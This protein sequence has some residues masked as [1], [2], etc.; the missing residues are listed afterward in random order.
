MEPYHC[1]P[2]AICVESAECDFT[3]PLRHCIQMLATWDTPDHL[4][5]IIGRHLSTPQHVAVYVVEDSGQ[6]VIMPCG[7]ILQSCYMP[8]AAYLSAWLEGPASSFAC[9]K[10]IYNGF[11]FFNYDQSSSLRVYP[12]RAARDREFA[13]R[14]ISQLLPRALTYASREGGEM[15]FIIRP[16]F[17]GRVRVRGKAVIDHWGEKTVR[18][19]LSKMWFS[20][21]NQFETLAGTE[22]RDEVAA[23]IAFSPRFT[24]SGAVASLPAL[25]HTRYPSNR[26]SPS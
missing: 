4:R 17:R 25:D 19:F 9:D 7:A 14:E 5:T 21:A 26:R 12:I 24:Y 2:Q 6:I 1:K 23:R 8:T 3:V 18:L 11:G 22:L 13:E 16:P 15:P 10:V 20:P